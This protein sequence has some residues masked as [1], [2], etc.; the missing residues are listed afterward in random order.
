MINNLA[1]SN[2]SIPNISTNDSCR[3]ANGNNSRKTAVLERDTNS[4]HNCKSLEIC[5]LSI[6][7]LPPSLGLNGQ[8]K[9]DTMLDS[10]ISRKKS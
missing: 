1:S 5:T 10:C 9:E 2:S 8:M 7:S 4:D 3:K 6:N